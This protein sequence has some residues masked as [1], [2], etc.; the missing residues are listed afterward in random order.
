M[1]KRSDAA[2]KLQPYAVTTVVGKPTPRIDAYDKVTGRTVYPTDIR[3][4]NMAHARFV[5]SSRTHAR[6]V[7]VDVTPA[8]AVPGFL[9][10][11]LPAE[12]AG[13]SLKDVLGRGLPILTEEPKYFGEEILAVCAETE[14]AA[15]EAARRVRVEYED[16]PHAMDPEQQVAAG[17][18]TGGGWTRTE[19]G[20]PAVYQRGDVR[21]GFAQA[22]RIFERTYRTAPTVHC[23]IEPHAAVASWED[24]RWTVW[25]S[26]QGVFAVREELAKLLDAPVRHVRV[27]GTHV[28]GGFGSKVAAGKYTFVASYLSKKLNRP[29]RCVQ[30]RTEEFVS[31]YGRPPSIQTLKIGVRSDGKITAIEQKG[32]HAVGPYEFG[33]E[34]GNA[35]DMPAETYACEHVRTE[36]YAA[37][38]N[39]P[40][41]CA[42][43]APGHAQA[44]FALEQMIDEIAAEL[45]IDPVKFRIKNLP[46]RDPVSGLPYAAPAGVHG[47]A[48]CLKKGAEM[49]QWS[50]KQ[51]EKSPVESPVK[52]GIGVAATVWTGGG[53][54][55]ASV[56]L[57]IHPDGAA[58]LY[59]GAADIGTGTR[60]AFAQIASEE[61]GV[62]MEDIR[63]INADTQLTSYTQPSY[64]SLTLASTGPAV[65]RAAVAVRDQLAAIAAEV[66]ET[67]EA[68]IVFSNGLAIRPAAR[69]KPEKSVS[70]AELVGGS[71]SREIVG[72]GER[73]RNPDAKALKAHGVQFVSVEVDVRTGVIRLAELVAVNDSGKV[74][75]PLGFKSQQFGGATMGLGMALFE[76]RVF[77]QDT[78]KPL[79]ANLSDYKVPTIMDQPEAFQVA[80]IEIPYDG[81]AIG[82]KGLGEPPI[83][84]TAAAIANAVFDATGV[85]IDRL[86]L[87]PKRILDA[88]YPVK[89][90]P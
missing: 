36:T 10:V 75:N 83:I 70:L 7:S 9:A 56:V 82:A 54:P 19:I 24:G 13:C 67:P 3:L 64:G 34:W 32:V 50:K 27:I 69:K 62:R 72:N 51:N 20:K 18:F 38:T 47:L 78:G 23:S 59:V 39:R 55:P 57:R 42:M 37:L 46:S 35:E 49:F 17:Q 88:L 86:P 68:Q 79:N 31:P 52:R 33:S 84:P 81:N 44:A 29:V 21:K 58:D 43:R 63:V 89:A 53:S 45:R 2:P 40:P 22:A 16:L 12:L 26:T 1:K 76:E 71:P 6:I 77:D 5:R 65:R 15:R 28:G 66:L 11:V 87:T 14:D 74:I 8:E 60:T 4:P 61:T 25:E 90:G 80:S 73:E 85:R 41:P 48:E 30:D